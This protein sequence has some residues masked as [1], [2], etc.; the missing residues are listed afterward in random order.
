M[1]DVVLEG[2]A[3]VKSY[4]RRAP[5]SGGARP[6]A[7]RPA[8]GG[9]SVTLNR[10][11]VLGVVGE[12]GSGKTTLARCLSMLSQP[13]SGSVLLDGRELGSLRGRELRRTRRQVQVI[14]QDPYASLNPR[15]SVGS[16]IE[17]VL[18]VHDLVPKEHIEGRIKELLDVVGLPASAAA[19]FPN[20]FSGGQRQRICIA[21]ALAAEP[22]VLVADEAVSGLDVS[23]QAQVLN[24]LLSLR[25]KLGLS[26]V[27]I[28]HDLHVVRRVATRVVVMFGGR[29]VESLP[30]HMRLEAARHPYT[31]LLVRTAPRIDA[32][33]LLE[34]LPT[35]DSSSG[36]LPASGCPFRQRCPLV[37]DVCLR[38]DPDLRPVG[39]DVLVACHHVTQHLS[40]T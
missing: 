16:V 35:G 20:E 13:D 37:S 31:Q 1:A 10:G 8:L 6:D 38:E 28:S 2:R 34:T 39:E 3:L 23:I 14:F 29:I 9:V 11:E 18:R 5:K 25:E 24:L 30:A 32:P 36:R 7:P 19:R 40:E 15:L 22:T 17:E 27:F 33:M 12:S 21:R 26:I 4:G